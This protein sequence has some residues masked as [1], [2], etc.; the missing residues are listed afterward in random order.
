MVRFGRPA[1]A[2]FLRDLCAFRINRGDHDFAAELIR[3]WALPEAAWSGELW[4]QA[5]AIASTAG[6]SARALEA[7]AKAVSLGCKDFSALDQ[8]VAL[9]LVNNAPEK[10]IGYLEAAVEDW[11]GDA[12]FAGRVIEVVDRFF[13]SLSAKAHHELRGGSSEQADTIITAGLDR[14]CSTLDRLM[15]DP[16]R[17]GSTHDGPVVMLAHRELRQCNHYRVEQKVEWFKAAGIDLRVHDEGDVDG[18]IAD[19]VG[20]HS[21]I[22]YRVQAT[23]GVVRAILTARKMGLPTFYEI[24]DLLFDPSAYPPPAESFTPRLSPQVYRGLRFAVP[25][26]RYALTM[27]DQMELT[28]AGRGEIH[29]VSAAALMAASRAAKFVCDEG[30]QIFGG[31]GY[32]RDTEINRLY[33][34]TKVMEIAAGSQE[35]RQTI[36]AKELLK[37]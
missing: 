18:F 32:M 12:R 3:E 14:I 30:V 7:Q 28:Q 29:K 31:S 33:R 17:L 2:G 11:R 21:A 4:R 19:L 24:D 35:I 34:T 6:D 5:A 9:A 22:F 27:C 20:A 16:A 15:A 26:F 37:G 36:I 1:G 13:E 10:A 8:L 23:P 25:L